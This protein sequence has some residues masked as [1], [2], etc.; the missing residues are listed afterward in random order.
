MVLQSGSAA[1]QND[2][3]TCMWSLGSDGTEPL[4]TLY[5]EDTTQRLSVSLSC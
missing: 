3:E 5:G 2:F 1:A 4:H